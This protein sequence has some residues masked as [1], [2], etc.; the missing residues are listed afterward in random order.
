MTSRQALLRAVLAAVAGTLVFAGPTFGV[1][2][3]TPGTHGTLRDFVRSGAVR[4]KTT[5]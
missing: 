4:R 3:A 1:R 5:R 2:Q